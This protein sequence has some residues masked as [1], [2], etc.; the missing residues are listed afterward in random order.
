MNVEGMPWY[1]KAEP[2]YPDSG[3]PKTDDD[4]KRGVSLYGVGHTGRSS[5]GADF[6]GS[7]RDIYFVLHPCM[8]PVA[9]VIF[10][11]FCYNTNMR[12]SVFPKAVQKDGP[13]N[14]R[15]WGK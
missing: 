3:L 12:K 4:K 6:G 8:A 10:W 15:W 11:M 13:A 9:L 14:G 1:R 7:L 2:L 5:C